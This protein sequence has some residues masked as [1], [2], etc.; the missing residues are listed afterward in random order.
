MASA[1]FKIGSGL[2]GMSF[3][4]TAAAA[5]SATSAA[6]GPAASTSASASL[7]PLSG[8]G[9]AFWGRVAIIGLA[10]V[11]YHGLPA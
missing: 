8:T 10:V 2:Q 3:G 11:C 4:P 9:L 5:P 6:Y 1:S 7:S